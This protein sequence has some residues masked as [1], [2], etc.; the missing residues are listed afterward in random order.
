MKNIFHNISSS[1]VPALFRASYDVNNA[2]LDKIAHDME[3][4]D[5]MLGVLRMKSLVNSR[6]RNAKSRFTRGRHFRAILE[7][8]MLRS[9]DKV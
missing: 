2:N 7:N 8:I 1:E 9:P 5:I 3:T 6:E 4:I